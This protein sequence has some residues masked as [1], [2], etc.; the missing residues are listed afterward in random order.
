MKKLFLILAVL[1]WT[2]PAFAQVNFSM[3]YDD[4]TDQLTISYVVASGD[5]PSGIA[6]RLN[7]DAVEGSSDVT[8]N[9]S[10]G[11]EV[12]SATGGDDFLVYLDFA[13]NEED[14]GDGY[15]LN[16]G[17][18]LA[19]WIDAP[20]DKGLPTLPAAKVALCMG[21]LRD[22]VGDPDYSGPAADDIAVVQ[23]NAAGDS[24]VVVLD[25]DYDRGG[26]VGSVLQTNLDTGGI[27]LSTGASCY[28][29]PDQAEFLAVGSPACW[30]CPQQCFGDANCTKDDNGK[31]GSFWVSGPDLDIL[32]DGWLIAYGG[33]PVA[34]P[35]I[36]ADFNHTN[37]DNG[38]L[39]SFRVAGPDL[40]ILSD[41]WLIDPVPDT[42]NQ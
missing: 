36:C 2:V 21:H 1:V 7:V 33:D 39:G 29:G 26:V 5:N 8:S 42:C 41:W 12:T 31:L 23:L 20:G 11:A 40:D 32:G 19:K 14:S 27:E 13:W 10:S 30:C 38:K 22:S 28:S 16:E 35:W 15:D 18:P 25:L 34:Q 37:D 3:A 17:H 6:L 9:G 24:T 4:G